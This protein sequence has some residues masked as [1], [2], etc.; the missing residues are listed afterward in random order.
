MPNAKNRLDQAIDKAKAAVNPVLDELKAAAGPGRVSNFVR[1]LELAE[2]ARRDPKKAAAELAA[3][4]G[5]RARLIAEAQR[6][7]AQRN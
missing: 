7:A 6:V 5:L 2:L 3:D 1:V 4:P